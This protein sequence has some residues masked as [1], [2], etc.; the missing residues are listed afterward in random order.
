MFMSGAID[1]LA[2]R[3]LKVDLED[4][5][6]EIDLS[7]SRAVAIAQLVFGGVWLCFTVP[8]IFAFGG[9]PIYVMAFVAMF[10]LLGVGM[11]VGS[12]SMLLRRRFVRFE[13]DCVWVKERKWFTTEEWYAPYSDYEGVLWREHTRRSK[14]SS[15]TFQIIELKHPED[16]KTLPLLVTTKKKSPRQDWN[17]YAHKLGLTALRE[18]GDD[19]I[20]RSVDDLGKSLKDLTEESKVDVA[21]DPNEA[22][23]DGLMTEPV[24][25]P[26]GDGLKVTVTAPLYPLAVKV[27]FY[28]A[29]SIFIVIGLLVPEA[30]IA[31]LAGGGFMVLVWF[32]FRHSDN[33][34]RFILLTRD[35]VTVHDSSRSKGKAERIVPLDDIAGITV[36]RSRSGMG[37]ELRIG[38]RKDEI[39]FGQG[40]S[41][42]ALDWLKRY[43][44]AAIATA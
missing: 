8:F 27:L 3:R 19:V 40:M 36:Q 18:S 21:W 29:P 24:S 33:A 16:D 9:A 4:R 20:K 28:L 42:D 32:I 1:T 2:L 35:N 39:P 14:N 12:L 13:R 38:S 7:P 31:A 30:R 26:D 15:T 37:P 6:E 25:L 44:T 22:V 5:S 17:D 34:S 41:S 11:V 10:P 43:L 23:P